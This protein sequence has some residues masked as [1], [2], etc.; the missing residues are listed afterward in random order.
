LIRI[1]RTVLTMAVLGLALPLLVLTPGCSGGQGD[2][3]IQSA[4]P[5]SA[6]APQPVPDDVKKGG[7]KSSSGQMNKN[8]G[9]SS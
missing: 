4:P 3:A 7:G 8:P 1:R 5:V 6:P 2:I 9:A